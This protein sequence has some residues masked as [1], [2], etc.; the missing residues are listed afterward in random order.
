[1]TLR[2]LTLPVTDF[3]SI[4]GRISYAYSYVK[5]SVYAGGNV[6]SYSTA[7]GD[8]AKYGGQI[9]W[10]D[11][12][13]WN[14]IERNVLGGNSTLLGGYDRPHR[15]SYNLI[16]RF[17]EEIILSSVGTFQSGFFFPL[18]LGDPRKRELGQSPQRSRWTSG[19][20][21]TI[22]GISRSQYVDVLNVF[23]WRTSSR[24]TAQRWSAGME[25][26]G[27]PTGGPTINRPIGISASSNDSSLIYDIPREV[28]F[29]INYSFW[30][31]HSGCYQLKLNI[32]EVSL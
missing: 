26:T 29:G 15:V 4:G 18:T 24:T 16:L 22:Q 27:D 31:F 11:I 19:E 7:A 32:K 13:R 8:S 9:P 23:G 14:T 10:E 12:K 25:R 2:K 21:I 1:V 28:F 6:T 5:Q 3:L 17:P 20:K 30:C